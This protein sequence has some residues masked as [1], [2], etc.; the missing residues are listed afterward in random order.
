MI[1][2]GKPNFGPANFLPQNYYGRPQG[3]FHGD[4]QG[5][6][7]GHYRPDD[8]NYGRP[9]GERPYGHDRYENQRPFI[10]YD[11]PEFYARSANKNPAKDDV[12]STKKFS[13]D[14]P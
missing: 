9:Y 7:G 14:K 3:N 1:F 10:P 6:L 5:H 4:Y 8:I 12:S 11:E 13:E 2:Q